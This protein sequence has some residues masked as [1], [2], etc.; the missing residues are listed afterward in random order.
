MHLNTPSLVICFGLFFIFSDCTMASL[1]IFSGCR[2]IKTSSAISDMFTGW[3]KRLNNI[4]YSLQFTDLFR[5]EHTYNLIYIYTIHAW[6]T[7]IHKIWLLITINAQHEPTWT[8]NA[9]AHHVWGSWLSIFAL[10]DL[11]HLA[12]CSSRDSLTPKMV[13]TSIDT[14]VLLKL[15]HRPGPLPWSLAP[16]D[17]IPNAWS[18]TRTIGENKELNRS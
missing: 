8:V 3:L 18:G 9:R 14:F 2:T 5:K 4:L 15:F 17:E 13:P 11:F 12:K 7:N 6:F 16:G 1:A 10:S